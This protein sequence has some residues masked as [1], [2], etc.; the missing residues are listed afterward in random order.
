MMIRR[1]IMEYYGNGLCLWWSNYT[2]IQEC[3]GSPRSQDN[4]INSSSTLTTYPAAAAVG[5]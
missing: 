2:H 3:K 5:E 1:I 4:E